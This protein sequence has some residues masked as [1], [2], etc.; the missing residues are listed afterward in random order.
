MT[1]VTTNRCRNCGE[2]NNLLDLGFI[3]QVAPFF[4]K[5]VCGVRLARSNR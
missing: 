1:I 3:G 5:R 4:L 2:T